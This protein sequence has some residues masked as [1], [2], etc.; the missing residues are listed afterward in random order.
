MGKPLHGQ[1]LASRE[2]P[3]LAAPDKF[4]GSLTASEAAQALA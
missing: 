2:M 1:K 4:R 3:L